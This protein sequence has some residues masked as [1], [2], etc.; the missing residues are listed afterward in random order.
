MEGKSKM[1]Y[2]GYIFSYVIIILYAQTLFSQDRIIYLLPDVLINALEKEIELNIREYSDS[3]T[4][5]DLCVEYDRVN[6]DII[7]QVWDLKDEI[8]KKLSDDSNRG[9]LLD[10][11]RIINM[12]FSSDIRMSTRFNVWNPNEKTMRV[13]RINTHYRVI[14]YNLGT[15]KLKDTG[16]S[17]P[18][19]RK[20]IRK[21]RY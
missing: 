16:S 1:R 3:I 19:R 18:V 5:K 13:T 10:S 20:K 7:I 8:I 17:Y 11:N 2:I 12:F 14:I 4:Y 21:M 6:D 15:G 9:I